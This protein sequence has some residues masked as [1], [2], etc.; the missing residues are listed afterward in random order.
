MKKEKEILPLFRQFIRDTESGKRLKK[1]GERIKPESVKNYQYVLKNLE[2]FSMDCGFDLR[3]CDA[4]RL[5]GREYASEKSYWKRFYRRFVEYLYKR[6]CHDNYAGANVKT[7]RVFFTYLRDD[8][9]FDTGNFQRM[10]YVRKEEVEIL[11]LSPEQLRLLMYDGSLEQNLSALQQ[12]VKDMFLFGCLTGL[13]F[14][15]LMQ[16]APHNIERQADTWYLKL[17]SKKTK[18]YSYIRLPDYAVAIYEKYVDGLNSSGKLFGTLTL[19]TFNKALKEVGKAAGFT[20]PINVTR[21]KQGKPQRKGKEHRFCDR[22]SSHMMRRT[23]I[24]TMLVLG[25]PEH[26]VRKVSGHSN[27][28]PSFNRYVHY[29]QGYMDTEL[30]KV[31]NRLAAI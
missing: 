27:A 13:R 15:D 4:S 22:M 23:A 9:D 20:Q 14:S 18:T 21:E 1:N 16:V 24:T 26:L 5:N 10:F 2:S 8:K 3:I 19:F 30:E 17:R 31:H 29:A 12:R 7:I 25:M 6:G 28:S 11:V